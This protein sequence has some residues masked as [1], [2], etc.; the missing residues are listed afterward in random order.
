MDDKKQYISRVKLADGTTADVK[1]SEA[2][3]ILELLFSDT[4]I[5]DCGTSDTIVDQL[6]GTEANN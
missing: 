3:S 5:L 1:D 6:D 4:I 2:R